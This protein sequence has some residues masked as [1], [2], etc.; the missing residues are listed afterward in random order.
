MQP[1]V[2]NT[3][4]FPL[5][6]LLAQKLTLE[7]IEEVRVFPRRST[8]APTVYLSTLALLKE[9]DL[10]AMEL[11][12][13]LLITGFEAD[14]DLTG[15]QANGMAARLTEA[16]HLEGQRALELVFSPYQPGG[17][18]W[19]S[20]QARYAE[21]GLPLRDWSGYERFC[22]EARNPGKTEAPLKLC[23]RDLTG[24]QATLSATVP[25]GGRLAFSG[26][27]RELALDL[28]SLVQVDLFMSEP[29]AAHTV[30]IDDLR[31][32]AAPFEPADRLLERLNRSERDAARRGATDLSTAYR[33]TR[34]VVAALRSGLEQRRTFG[35]AHLLAEGVVAAGRQADRL[36]R[37]LQAFRPL[38]GKP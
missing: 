11:P 18:R 8:R 30:W 15:W 16:A 2:W 28:S 36:D 14:K 5:A 21:R 23:F 20:Y 38:Q 32:E 24:A 17:P 10:K 26:S 9:R 7:K 25:A 33:Q 3:L 6:E 27:L 19:P 37:D 31:L 4:I 35:G 34:E 1:K 13:R 22:F 12:L 29:A